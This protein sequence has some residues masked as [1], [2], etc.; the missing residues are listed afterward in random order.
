MKKKTIL[1]ALFSILLLGVS[2]CSNNKVDP[3]PKVEEQK[4]DSEAQNNKLEDNELNKKIFDEFKIAFSGSSYDDFLLNCDTYYYNEGMKCYHYKSGYLSLDSNGLF[5]SKI[6]YNDNMRTE[7]L[8]LNNEW[9]KK[10]EEENI[11]GTYMNTYVLKLNN[12]KSFNS[13]TEYKYN[14]SGY[15]LEEIYSKYENNTWIYDCKYE[16]NYNG[17]GSIVNA[18]RYA[19]EN[20]EWV[21]KEQRNYDN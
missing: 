13:K 4:N 8:Y 18:K 19:Y 16:Y 21:L 1:Y 20:G 12:D 15:K 10:I 17:N 14:E 2:A 3:N 5:S 6:V 11:N 9:V 7:S